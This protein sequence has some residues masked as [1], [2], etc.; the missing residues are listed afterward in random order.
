MVKPTA[1]QLIANVNNRL[2]EE[3]GLGACIDTDRL[4]ADIDI[5]RRNGDRDVTVKI[6]SFSEFC[7]SFEEA[8]ALLE[9][10]RQW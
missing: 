9:R 7:L 1:T 8:R 6:P 4:Q 5:A 2:A 3:F 10:S